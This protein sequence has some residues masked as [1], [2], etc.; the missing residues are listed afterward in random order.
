MDTELAETILRTQ[1]R[2]I[3]GD[4]LS[5]AQALE[6]AGALPDGDAWM[7]FIEKP[8]KWA[9]AYAA[10]VDNGHPM[11]DVDPKYVAGWRRFLDAIDGQ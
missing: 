4:F 7:T 10:W 8:W 9:D 1:A 2:L 5:F 3:N 6:T 11:D